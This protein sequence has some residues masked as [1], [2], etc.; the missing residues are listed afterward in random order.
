[1]N[2]KFTR[3]ETTSFFTKLVTESIESREE[4]GIVRQD[5]I[6]LLMLAKKGTLTYDDSDNDSKDAGFATVEESAIG[7]KKIKTSKYRYF[8]QIK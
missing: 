6:H 7:K 3:P 1:M 2:I 5:M 8:S 4:S